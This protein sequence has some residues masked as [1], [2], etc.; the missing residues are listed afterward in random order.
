MSYITWESRSKSQNIPITSIRCLV[1]ALS[2]SSIQ[3]KNVPSE[4]RDLIRAEEQYKVALESYQDATLLTLEDVKKFEES[5]GII[6]K[7]NEQ[8]H[9]SLLVAEQNPPS[10]LEFQHSG[11]TYLAEKIVGSYKISWTEEVE[12]Y[13][14]RET[15]KKKENK[16]TESFVNNLCRTYE[17]SK[18]KHASEL[19]TLQDSMAEIGAEIPDVLAQAMRIRRAW[20]RSDEKKRV[21]NLVAERTKEVISNANSLGFTHHT[22][23]LNDIDEPEIIVTM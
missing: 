12:K 18:S 1:Y 6:V 16:K 3:L 9:N 15:G 11:V 4:I 14:G 23:D 21:D 5:I 13:D 19:K 8:L 17:F 7:A 22:T 10:V 2:N 20:E